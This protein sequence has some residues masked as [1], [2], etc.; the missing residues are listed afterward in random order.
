MFF[1]IFGLCIIYQEAN[2]LRWQAEPNIF[3]KLGQNS[4]KL[5]LC[6]SCHMDK[7]ISFPP[8]PVLQHLFSFSEATL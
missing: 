6:E 5:M 7:G 4:W 3:S 8:C 1:P 2:K